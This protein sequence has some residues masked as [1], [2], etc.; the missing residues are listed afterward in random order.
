MGEPKNDGAG[1]GDD[2]DDEKDRVRSS[3][4]RRL[5]AKA[6]RRARPGWVVGSPCGA[7]QKDPDLAQTPS[8][9]PSLTA[10][11][12]CSTA[13]FSYMHTYIQSVAL[14]ARLVLI[15]SIKELSSVGRIKTYQHSITR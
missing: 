11:F 10:L 6:G 8:K 12:V 2:D 5:A 1:G 15:A 4:E 3:S 7:R 13:F 9:G 14:A